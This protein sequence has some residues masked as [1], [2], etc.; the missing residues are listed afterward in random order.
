MADLFQ[1]YIDGTWQA[2]ATGQTF[3]S[4]N[5]ASFQDVVGHFPASGPADVDDAVAAAQSVFDSWS[6]TP[7][8]MPSRSPA[9]PKSARRSAKRADASIRSCRSKWAAKIP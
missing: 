8:S 2:A 3:A 5:P 4:R 6:S 9:P 1:N 7:R